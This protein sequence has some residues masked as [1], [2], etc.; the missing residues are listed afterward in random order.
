MFVRRGL[1]ELR[2]LLAEIGVGRPYVTASDRW[3]RLDVPAAGRWSE[4]PSASPNRA[5]GSAATGALYRSAAGR[6]IAFSAP[7]GNP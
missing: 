5:I 7:C 3:S 2:P 6:Q 4:V 1:G